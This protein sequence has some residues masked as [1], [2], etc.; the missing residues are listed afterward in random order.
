MQIACVCVYNNSADFVRFA[1]Q[2]PQSAQGQLDGASRENNREGEM[3]KRE[4]EEQMGGQ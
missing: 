2:A 1:M 3:G 4:K